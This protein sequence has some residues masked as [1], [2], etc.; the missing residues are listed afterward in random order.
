MQSMMMTNSSDF[1]L[2]FFLLNFN[3]IHQ[4]KN[5]FRLVVLTS[6]RGKFFFFIASAHAAKLC[7]KSEINQDLEKYFQ[8]NF[9]G[10]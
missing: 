9:D 8:S 3:S 4:Q 2:A 10:K 1:V 6:R 7:L 5:L